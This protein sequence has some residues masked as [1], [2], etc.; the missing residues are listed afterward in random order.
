[1]PCHS[2]GQQHG[3]PKPW[4][5]TWHAKALASSMPCLGLGKHVMPRPW[6]AAC[7]A[8]ALASSMPCPGLGQQHA[9]PRPWPAACHA[10]ALAS[11]MPCHSLGQQHGMPTPWP[12][13]C[14]ALAL[15]SMSCHGLGQQHAMPR[16]W[17]AACHATALASSMPCHGLG[18]QHAM[19][20]PWP[21]TWHAKAL[22]S[23]TPCPWKLVA[24]SMSLESCLLRLLF[25]FALTGACSASLNVFARSSG[26]LVL[27]GVIR[28]GGLVHSVRRG[29]ACASLVEGALR[30]ACPSGNCHLVGFDVRTSCLCFPSG[31]LLRKVV[32]DSPSG[33]LRF[34]SGRCLAKSVRANRCLLGL[35]KCFRAF[36]GLLSPSGA[37]S[38]GAFLH[39][40]RVIAFRLSSTR[41]RVVCASLVEGALRKA[42]PSGNCHLVGFDVRT[43]CLC[44]PSGSFA[45]TGACSASLNVFA[46]SS[47]FLVLRG[48]IRFGGLVHSVRRG[49]PALS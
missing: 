41:L 33:C 12:A 36:V 39:V 37:N 35:S 9:M 30:K 29:V 5:A 14:H 15:A 4:P 1:M 19:P 18:Q 11:S 38:T 43:S 47:G 28:F 34:P 26:F 13:A 21:A 20:Q 44:F 8:T 31:S 22:A 2:L 17:P 23:S 7:H 16:P 40:P 25:A 6:P 48:V 24:R 49:L 32:F 46:R 10:T 3:M 42:C 27:R 45:L